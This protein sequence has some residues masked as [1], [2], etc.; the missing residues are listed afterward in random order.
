M[1]GAMVYLFFFDGES[2]GGWTVFFISLVLTILFYTIDK[3]HKEIEAL[4]KPKDENRD[5][6]QVIFHRTSPAKNEDVDEKTNN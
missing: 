2:F 4:R 1:S 3:Q 6:M 5:E